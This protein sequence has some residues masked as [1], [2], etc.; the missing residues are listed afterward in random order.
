MARRR[1]GVRRRIGDRHGEAAQPPKPSRRAVPQVMGGRRTV[2]PRPILDCFALASLGLAMTARL[3]RHG[4]AAQPP[5][6]SRR[7]AP[8][9]LGGRPNLL[10]ARFRSASRSLALALAMTGNTGRAGSP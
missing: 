7:A 2:V 4:E 5:K 8:R 1:I 3:P 6:P 10:P 9:I